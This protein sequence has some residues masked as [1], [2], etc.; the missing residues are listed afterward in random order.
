MSCAHFNLMLSY[1]VTQ[2]MHSANVYAMFHLE[3]ALVDA[4]ARIMCENGS[5]C[6]QRLCIISLLLLLRSVFVVN[7]LKRKCVRRKKAER[8][9]FVTTN[10]NNS[11]HTIQEEKKS[12]QYARS[13]VDDVPLPHNHIV[14]VP[15][16]THI[17]IFCFSTISA[18][19]LCAVYLYVLY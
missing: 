9:A 4:R 13:S 12:G 14:F 6:G 3:T 11:I 7:D 16:S 19:T 15:N 10:R 17:F 5:C 2:L 1:T 8:L 18:S